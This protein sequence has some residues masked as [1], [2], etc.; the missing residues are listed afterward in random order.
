MRSLTIY[1]FTERDRV[2]FFIRVTLKYTLTISLWRKY[3]IVHGSILYRFLPGFALR[4][5]ASCLALAPPPAARAVVRVDATLR[6]GCADRVVCSAEKEGAGTES[7]WGLEEMLAADG[8]GHVHILQ[9]VQRKILQTYLTT[10]KFAEAK[11]VP[12]EPVSSFTIL[13]FVI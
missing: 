7:G 3:I 8:E 4:S 5:E 11:G 10:H 6:L 13:P 1:Y 2:Y 9:F 12:H